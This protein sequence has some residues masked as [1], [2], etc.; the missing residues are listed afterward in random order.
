MKATTWNTARC[1]FCA[2]LAL[3]LATGLALA[4]MAR[5]QT[6]TVLYNFAGPTD[7]TNPL[8]GLTMDHAGNLYGTTS[9]GAGGGWGSVYRL[10]RSGSNWTFGLL[11]TFRGYEGNDAGAP[12]SRV[13]IGPDGALYGATHSGGNGQGCRE[14]H[15]CG[16]VYKVEPNSG[17]IFSPWQ[18]TVLYQ[19]GTYDGSDPLYGDVVFDQAGN[20]YGATRDGG[21][22]LLGAVYELTPNNGSWSES[23]VHSFSGPDG[24]TPLTGPAVDQYGNLYGTTSAGGTSG[25]GAVYQLAPSSS[26]WVENVLHS[27]QNGN[28]GVTPTSSVILDQVGNLYGA[29]QSG[30]TGGGG[31]AF[32][33]TPVGGGSWNIAT[34]YGFTGSSFGGSYRTLA[35]D[36]AGN[37]YGTAAADGANK[38]GSVFRLTWSNGTWIHTTLYDFT[39]N[40]DGGYPYGSLIL[41]GFGNIY[42]TASAGGAYGNGVVFQI[43]P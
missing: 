43:T 7:G 25:W 30:G 40:G 24:S 8:A 17:G 29:T 6:Y 12:Y 11:Y 28:V 33:L 22:Y 4:P 1:N 15:G 21:A 20:L 38:R 2:T 13:T 39:G 32:E 37:L 31:T 27:F 26:T 14:L 19:F 35:M 36:S 41:D 23:V 5:A 18:E 42:G 16:T 10:V 34:L 9:A 3:A